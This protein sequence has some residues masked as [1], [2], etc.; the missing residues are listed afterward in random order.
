MTPEQDNKDEFQFDESDQ[1]AIFAHIK[2]PSDWYDN[3]PFEEKFGNPALLIPM[4]NG[5]DEPPIKINYI[6]SCSEQCDWPNCTKSNCVQKQT[7]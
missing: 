6:P 1:A 3:R 7:K 4:G 2:L 5:K